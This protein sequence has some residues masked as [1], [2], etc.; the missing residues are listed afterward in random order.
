MVARAAAK[1]RVSRGARGTSG[2]RWSYAREVGP[3]RLVMVDSR[4]GRVLEGGQRQLLDEDEW[5]WLA[6]EAAQPASYLLVGTSLPLLLPPGLHELERVTTAA[7]AGRWGRLGARVGEWVRRAA[8]FNHWAAFPPSF[9]R[10]LRVLRDAATPPRKAVVVLSGDVH[11]AYQATINSWGDGT[12]PP[13]PVHQLV[14]SPQCYDLYRTIAGGFRSIISRPGE[15]F[16]RRVSRA[17]GAPP[18]AADWTIEAGPVLHNNVTH[19]ELSPEDAHVRFERTRADGE[20]GTRLELVA[21]RSL[22]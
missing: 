4:D 14:S 22:F 15:R 16:G 19:L 1:R 17:A 20:L 10:A 5:A 12:S 9:A 11:Y 3:A 21:E 2:P 13:V 18:T 8:Q 6:D 7:C